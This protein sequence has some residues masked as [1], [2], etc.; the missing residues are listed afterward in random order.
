[1]SVAKVALSVGIL[2]LSSQFAGAAP[3]ARLS[4]SQAS[5]ISPDYQKTPQSS[6]QFMT[7]GVDTLA[8]FRSEA[9]IDDS[10]QAQLRALV[11]PGAS[12]MNYLNINQLFWKQGPFSFGRKKIPWSLLDEEFALGIY[13]PLFK[14]N[15]LQMESQG[16]TG[17]FLQFEA[18]EEIPW[19]LTFFGSSVFIP[20]QGP[21]YEVEDGVFRSTNPY[22]QTPPSRAVVND[23]AFDLKYQLV[24]PNTEEIVFHQSFAGQLFFGK[25]HQGLYGQVAYALKPMNELNLGF[26]GYAPPA[27]R[28]LKV[29]ILPAVS[30]HTVLSSDLYYSWEHL[31]AGLSLVQERPREPKFGNDWTYAQFSNSN[32]FSPSVGWRE[33]HFELRAALLMLEGGESQGVGP[34]ANQAGALIPQRYPFRNAGM[35]SGKYFYHIRR[36]ENVTFSSRYLRGQDGEFDLWLTQAAYQWEKDWAVHLV[37]QMVA[38][39]DNPKGKLTA[40]SSSV[41]NDLLALGVS[42]VF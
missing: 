32:L 21:G 38:V 5:F 7:G 25:V 9:D 12:V 13:Q 28:Q 23:M 24:R 35:L 6:F 19:G 16:L 40:W 42:Y 27:D 31:R 3:R 11:A 15:P 1:M 33:D 18:T 4:L 10:L 34:N 8:G 20:N 30:D 37:S 36:F 14:G 39:Q 26:V 29:E 41:N 22:F 2:I 17:A